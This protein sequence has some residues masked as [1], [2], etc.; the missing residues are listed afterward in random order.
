MCE[1]T[2]QVSSH[3]VEESNDLREETV[4]QFDHEGPNASVPSSGWQEGE[5]LV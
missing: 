3:G 5:E 2:W 1:G 4:P